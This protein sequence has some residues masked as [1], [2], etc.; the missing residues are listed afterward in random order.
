MPE[1]YMQLQ[2]NAKNRRFRSHRRL[3]LALEIH[4]ENLQQHNLTR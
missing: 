2:L 1:A 3:A 4:L